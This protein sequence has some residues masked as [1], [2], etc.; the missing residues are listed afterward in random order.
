MKPIVL[1]AALL[2][3]P[4]PVAPVRISPSA[5]ASL[6]APSAAPRTAE[7]LAIHESVRA[8]AAPALPAEAKELKY[9]L[10]DGLFGN[11]IGDY[12]DGTKRRLRELGLDVVEPRVNTEGDTAGNLAVIEKSVRES[13]KPV[14]LVGHSRGGNMAH[15]WYRG[16]SRELKDKIAR[17][18]IMQAP[19][20]GTPHADETLRPWW[21]RAAI[22]AWGWAR[23]GV[24][25]LE[26]IRELTTKGRVSA[27]RSLPPW[28]PRDLEKVLVV[29]TRIFPEP[30]HPFYESARALIARLGGA[31]NDGRVPLSSAGIRGADDV[32]LDDVDHQQLIIENPDKKRVRKGY[33]PHP[34]YG[35][36]DVSEALVRLLFSSPAPTRPAAG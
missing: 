10:I 6:A 32:T 27:M 14:V 21:K 1:A 9:V 4:A 20:R 23:H 22:W 13:E 26:T 17:L 36:G 2:P 29:R 3:G 8:K 7:F 30:L 15:D 19:L 18:V 28:E 5:S 25:K 12:F 35:V 24:N 34:L 11:Q 31:D 33:A 16:A